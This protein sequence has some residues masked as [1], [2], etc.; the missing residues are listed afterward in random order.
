MNGNHFYSRAPAA[1]LFA[2]FA[3]LALSACASG[4]PARPAGE[5]SMRSQWDAGRFFADS[6][7][8]DLV[9]FGVSSRH[10]SRRDYDVSDAE[11]AGARLEAARLVAMRYG[12]SGT[13]ESFH[14]QGAGFFDY[15]FDSRVDL[16]PAVSDLDGIAQRLSFD[17]ARD[18]LVF[19]RGTIVRF[20]YP[21][22]ADGSVSSGP[23]GAGGRPG[24]VDG[25]VQP[26]SG[27]L[28]TAVGFSPNQL[29]LRDAVSRAAESA[30][31]RLI[32]GMNTSISTQLVDVAGQ[33]TVTYISSGGSGSLS[34]FRLLE[35]WIDPDT[36]GVYALAIAGLGD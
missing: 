5:P 27:G 30:A 26:A 9:V 7:G 31:A 18:V 36:L 32:S 2:A 24:W 28:M 3:A 4:G 22:R 15:I 33:G 8:G 13:V 12:V 17:P 35:F 25:A 19:D 21:A 23:A 29:W 6:R 16:T 1:A 34:G 10:V 14:R 20:R 11:L